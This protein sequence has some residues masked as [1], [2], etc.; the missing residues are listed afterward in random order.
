MRKHRRG[1]SFATR[2][3]PWS[4]D[5]EA[6]RPG[7]GDPA[8]PTLQRRGHLQWLGEREDLVFANTL[9]L[10]LVDRGLQNCV[11]GLA[12]AVEALENG[13]PRD[14]VA[15][16]PLAARLRSLIASGGHT[17][18]PRRA[19]PPSNGPFEPSGSAG[20]STPSR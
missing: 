15:A 3:I 11:K 1:S 4:A 17:A 16:K 19:P 8:S 10:G 9:L 12:D 2:T 18:D 13:G 7:G 14:A 6:V 20:R 5:T